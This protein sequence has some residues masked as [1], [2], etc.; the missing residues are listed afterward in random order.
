MDDT[1]IMSFLL[2]PGFALTSFSLSI[3][4]LS[5]A[6]SLLSYD[7]YHVHLYGEK[8]L[9]KQTAVTSSNGIPIQIEGDITSC[10]QTDTLFICAYLGAENFSQVE[11]CKQIKSLYRQQSRMACLS[12]GSFI[13][14]K[15]GLLKGKKCTVYNE[16][17][18]SF[19]EMYPDIDI[20]NTIFSVDGKILSCAGGTSALDMMLYIITQDYGKAFAQDV[21]EIFLQDRVRSFDEIQKSQRYLL[22]KEKSPLLAAAV[23]IMDENLSLTISIEEISHQIGTTPRNLEKIFQRNLSTTPKKYYLDIRLK[24]SLHL[25]ENTNISITGISQLTGFSSQSYFSQCF[26]ERYNS[27]PQKIRSNTA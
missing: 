10:K 2:V 16:Q 14:A 18:I 5:V 4:V 27:S 15:C 11:T 26:K 25:L 22:L 8:S 13:L 24:E 3:E 17:A 21:S 1:R 23:E 7:A 20:Q 6:N 9:V 12:S 19:K